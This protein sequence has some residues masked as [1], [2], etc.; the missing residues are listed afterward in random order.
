MVCVSSRNSRFF[1]MEHHSYLKALLTDKQRLFRWG[2]LADISSK[3]NEASLSLQGKQLTM[4]SP[5]LKSKLLNETQEFGQRISTTVSSSVSKYLTAY[6]YIIL[7]NHMQVKDLLKAQDRSMNFNVARYQKF[8][9]MVSDSTSQLNFKKLP[10]VEFWCRIK[11]DYPQ[12][13][14]KALLF[15]NYNPD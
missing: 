8:T 1:F 15:S 6:Q 5:N 13:S 11:E 9:N 4:W 10:L 14:E 3:M 7:Q 12:L 2:Y